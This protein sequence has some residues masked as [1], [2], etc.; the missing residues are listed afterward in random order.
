MM[1][2]LAWDNVSR[3]TDEPVVE[4]QAAHLDFE[5]HRH[6]EFVL[7]QRGRFAARNCDT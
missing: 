4:P 5:L 6:A 7:L 3:S 1:P 2:S